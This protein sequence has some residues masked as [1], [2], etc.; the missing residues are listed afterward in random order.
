MND[1]STCVYQYFD[2]SGRLLYVGITGRGVTRSHEHARSKDWWHLTTGC[3]I[4]HYATRDE[5]LAREAYLI[6]AYKPPH[7]TQGKSRS[8]S[9]ADL[10]DRLDQ[11]GE[12]LRS[13]DLS[14]PRV[15]SVWES[16]ARGDTRDAITR[17]MRLPKSLKRVIS[18][19]GCV[20]C[21]TRQPRPGGPLCSVCLLDHHNGLPPRARREIAALSQ[22]SPNA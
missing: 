7:N 6:A 2:Q 4:E 19:T 18:A 3:H 17:W 15:Q 5:A 8:V 16:A 10:A 1:Q 13:R 20:K 12:P 22:T 9:A 11:L 21:R 14:D